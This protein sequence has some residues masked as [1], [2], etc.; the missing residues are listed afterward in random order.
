MTNEMCGIEPATDDVR[1]VVR[2]QYREVRENS[3]GP[4]Q[5]TLNQFLGGDT[6]TTAGVAITFI[7]ALLAH[8]ETLATEDST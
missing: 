4:L 1:C 3:C 5:N 2:Q 8:Y 6:Q 7:V